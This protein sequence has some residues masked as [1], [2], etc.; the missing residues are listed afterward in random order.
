MT[1]DSDNNSAMI[2]INIIIYKGWTTWLSLFT[3]LPRPEISF[4][5]SSKMM[6]SVSMCACVLSPQ[7][8]QADHH[9]P[10]SLHG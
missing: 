8:T 5:G 7:P 6:I 2:K 10:R 3:N 9:P 4:N 1:W